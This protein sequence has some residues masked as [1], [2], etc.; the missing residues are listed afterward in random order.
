MS[1]DFELKPFDHIAGCSLGTWT[2][3][4][5]AVAIIETMEKLQ[6]SLG[7]E[8]YNLEID[9]AWR[10]LAQCADDDIDVTEYS[11]TLE[12]LFSDS[13][14]VSC[15]FS[16]GDGE[17]RVTPYVDHCAETFDDVPES[18]VDDYIYTVTDH[19]NV[20]CWSW[21]HVHKEYRHVWGMV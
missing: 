12:I 15:C 2:G 3:R 8:R 5:Q 10:D 16:W 18:F 19:G 14:P 11:D 21:D 4:D 9:S 7:T 6:A 20:D 13:L 1:I 17:F